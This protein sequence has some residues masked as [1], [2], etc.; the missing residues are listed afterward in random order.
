LDQRPLFI[1][2]AR[3]DEVRRR[4]IAGL[5]FQRAH[6]SASDPI[7]ADV[8]VNGAACQPTDAGF[9]MYDA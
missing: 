2:A 6:Q 1:G 5:R 8:A 7:V 3:H 9:S 4:E